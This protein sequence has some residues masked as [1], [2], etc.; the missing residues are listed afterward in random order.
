MEGG[1]SPV[2]RDTDEDKATQNIA[3]KIMALRTFTVSINT[4]K[5]IL[6]LCRQLATKW[7]L[8]SE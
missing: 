1:A 6:R 3:K 5:L 2:K 7:S 8:A 4:V